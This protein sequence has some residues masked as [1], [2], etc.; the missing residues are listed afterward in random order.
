MKI[1]IQALILGLT[2][3]MLTTAQAGVYMINQGKVQF[4][5]KG[6]PTFITITGKGNG[7]T[8]EMTEDQG[9]TSGKFILDLNSLSTDLELRDE[10][11]KNKYL[12]V[13]KFPNA[14]LTLP[15]K[16]LSDGGEIKATLKLKD[17]EKEIP[18]Q[19]EVSHEDGNKI[20]KTSFKVELS[21]FDIK[22]PSFQGVTV[23]K[24]INI[25][26]EFKAIAKK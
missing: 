24:T 12:E 7:L 8:G 25:N 17:V 6:F 21:D 2:F 5:A 23:A 19:Y 4:I 1:L 16:K 13:G 11:M 20:V 18:V 3:C 14:E 15:M 9:M 10:H 26:V 22:I